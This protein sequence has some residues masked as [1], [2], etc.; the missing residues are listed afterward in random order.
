MEKYL[1]RFAKTHW[2]IGKFGDFTQILW[3]LVHTLVDPTLRTP[4]E[5][6]VLILGTFKFKIYIYIIM[7]IIN[8]IYTYS[9]RWLFVGIISQKEL[10]KL[11]GIGRGV[12]Y[13]NLKPLEKMIL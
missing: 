5:L 10:K 3:Y 6:N 13:S 9:D 12:G 7:C 11:V 8:Y 4:S 1:G 2:I